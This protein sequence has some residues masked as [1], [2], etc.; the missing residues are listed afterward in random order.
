MKKHSYLRQV[1]GGNNLIKKFFQEL[2][3]LLSVLPRIVI[4][5]P[6][7]KNFGE[8]YFKA[9]IAVLILV[10]LYFAPQG[11]LDFFS[12][13]S[14]FSLR[15]DSSSKAEFWAKWGS[16]YAYWVGLLIVCFQRWKEI[17]R[18]PSVIDLGKFSM[19]SGDTPFYDWLRKMIPDRNFCNPRLYEI[20]YEPLVFIIAGFILVKLDQPL[21]RLFII[22]GIIHSI[23]SY[24]AYDR[25]DNYIMDIVDSEIAA[26]DIHS[27]LT[28]QDEDVISPTGLE[29]KMKK[30]KDAA[31]RKRI[32]DLINDGEE[33]TTE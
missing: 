32:A 6:L 5:A 10:L 4:E 17:W 31:N 30:P 2:F 8:R 18:N 25:A 28:A 29:L 24:G 7:R 1:Y 23:A 3:T 11:I 33:F 21:G 16:W 27:L 22:S 12:F 15:D 13:N 9:F 19:Y 14:R 26:K 20:V